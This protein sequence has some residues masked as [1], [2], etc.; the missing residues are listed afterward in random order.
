MAEPRY[1]PYDQVDKTKWDACINRAANGLIYGQSRYL[2]AMSKHWDALV[3]RDYEAVMPL[4]WNR[5]YAIHYLYQPAFTASLGVFG[6]HIDAALLQDFL[7]HIPGKFKYWDISLNHDNLFSLP[8]Y[9]LV[10]RMNYVLPLNSSHD[11]ISN[12]YRD[13]LKRNIRRSEQAGNRVVNDLDIPSAIALAKE[14]LLHLPGIDEDDFT[15]FE[16]LCGM[17]RETGSC[18]TYGVFD[19]RDKLV[20]SAIFLFSHNRAYYV[21]PGNHPDGKT[22]GASHALIDA[23]IKDHAGKD[24]LLDFEGSDISSLAFFYGSFGSVEEKYSAVRLNRLPGIVKWMKR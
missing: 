16:R 15:R 3:Y 23:F 2:D 13:N 10:E 7:D 6:N 14:Q 1:L 24:L 18:K 4:T 9:H 12:N 21:L 19:S 22:A 20:S 11:T 8:G 5:K 17:Y